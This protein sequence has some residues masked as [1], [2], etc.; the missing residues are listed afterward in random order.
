PGPPRCTGPGPPRFPASIPPPRRRMARW[1]PVPPMWLEGRFSFEFLS[2][3]RD[4]VFRGDDVPPGLR[5][6]VLLIPGFLAGDWTLRTQFDW[7]RRV[8]YRPR[9]AGVSFNVMYSEVMLKPLLD[10]LLAMHRKS[11]A[12]VSV[13]GHSRGGVLAEVLSHRKPD[14]VEQVIT[15]GS[16]LNDPLDVHP[17]NM[18]GVHAA[19]LFNAVR[20]RHPAS[21]EMRFLRD[22]GAAPR[23]PTTSVHS[24]SDG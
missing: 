22:L 2:L 12:R 16:P 4:P 17:L 3:L 15:L 23:L 11:G 10:A 21:V 1:D 20:Y 19:H 14:L 8:G 5:K 6:P 13:V 18:A 9:L 7:L 24:R